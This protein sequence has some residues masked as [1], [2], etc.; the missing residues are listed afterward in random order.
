MVVVAEPTLKPP[1]VAPA[2]AH[3]GHLGLVWALRSLI[4]VPV[5]LMAPEIWSGLLG[6]PHAAEHL[7]TSTASVLGT[8]SFLLFV[9][10]LMVTPVQT[11]TGW[12][13][14]VPLRRD[15]GVAMFAT[16]LLDLT[17]AATVTGDTFPGGFVTRVAGHAVLWAGTLATLLALPLA[18]TAHRRGRRWLGRHWKWFHRL[19]Y[20]LWAA[21]LLHLL[22]LFGFRGVFVHALFVSIALAVP[23]TP[24]LRRWWIDHRRART[25]AAARVALALALTGVFAAGVVPFVKTLVSDG[26]GAFTQHPADD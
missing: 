2:P 4:L 13:W 11:M 18:L 14:H 7:S 1:P 5:V 22:L 21:I 8:S 12:H 15:F 3:T 6:R 24:A 16:A 10:M 19:T 25:H 23:R 9:L 17:L 26:A 20:I